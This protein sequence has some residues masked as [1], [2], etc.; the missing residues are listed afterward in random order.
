MKIA[1]LSLLED[2]SNSGC[3][4]VSGDWLVQF[5]VITTKG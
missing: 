2:G 4:T 1:D 5:A 3:K